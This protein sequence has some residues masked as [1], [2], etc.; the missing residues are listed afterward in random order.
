MKNILLIIF[1]FFTSFIT[2]GQPEFTK[3]VEKKYSELPI[4]LRIEN[5]GI[6]AISSFDVENGNVWI[7]DFDTH[8]IYLIGGNKLQKAGSKIKIDNDFSSNGTLENSLTENYSANPEDC[9]LTLKKSF[10][11]NKEN[12]FVD[13]GGILTNSN[14]DKIIVKVISR[15]ELRIDYNISNFNK[16]FDY[17]NF[18]NLA[19]A[20]LIGIDSKGNSFLLVET[21]LQQTPLKIK[22]EIYTISSGGKILSVLEVPAIDYLYMVKDFQIDAAGNLYQ[23]IS[24]KD[25]IT[26]IKW[27]GLTNYTSAKINYPP[28]YNYELNYNYLTPNKE[29]VRNFRKTTGVETAS[30]VSALRIAESYALYKYNC[31]SNNLAPNDV[32]GPDGDV[33]RT[34]AWLILGE[35][36]KIPY[37]WGGFSTLTQF[38]EGLQIGKYAGDINTA[39]VSNYAVGVDC[40]GFV[41]R[42]W[43]LSYH[44]STSDMP[45]ITKQ[46]SSWDDLKPGDAIHKVGHVRLFVNRTSDGAL[47]VIESSARDWDVSYWTY[48]PSDLTAY[49]PRYY[50]GMVSD[51]SLQQPEL[52]SVLLQNDGNAEITWQCDTSNVI[53]YKLYKSD[54]G[55]TWNILKDITDLSSLNTTVS[56][57]D[58]VEYFRI[59]SVLNN[60]PSYSESDWSNVLGTG[61]FASAKKKVLI[62]D[63]FNRESGDWRANLT[64]FTSTYGEALSKLGINFE[65]VKNSQVINSDVDL[66][67]YDAVYWMLGDESTVDETFSSVEQIKVKN[68]LE[69]GGNLFVSGS[70]IGWDLDH[71]GNSMDKDFYHNYLK[72][73]Y[74]EDNSNSNYVSG[75]D[76]SSLNGSDFYFAQTYEVNYPD[77]IG[78]Y[79]G[80]SLCMKYSNG[81]GAGLE[82][83]GT[84][85]SSNALAKLINLGFPLESTAND[86]EFDSVISKSLTYFFSTVTSV[87]KPAS[88]RKSYDLS[89][90]YPN[91]FNPS[92]TIKFTIPKRSYVSL[93]VYDVLGR[94]I[95]TMV[96]GLR[97]EGQHK[98]IFTG[99][100]LA[101]G[102]YIYKLDVKPVDGLGS[103]SDVKKLLFLK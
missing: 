10:L 86:A 24:D 77:V 44:S 2:F 35:N 97:S 29:S 5:S 11:S 34:P 68:Y 1:T 84:F 20:E 88:N 37:M 101:S 98:V 22:K 38:K 32:K 6:Y 40:S 45:Y 96:N 48:K 7:Q 100:N 52:K 78:S 76:N 50:N 47:R 74:V 16:Y 51:Y 71:K 72:A 67:K 82:Y 19:Y 89:Q 75:V 53:A 57:D 54:D 94:L 92:T 55:I 15:N 65:S 83:S 62:V 4:H 81:K 14:N 43:N 21:Y 25:K 85:G 66:T 58:S 91:P 13:N 56:M 30:R 8:K 28:E 93:K 103:F 31:N 87:A 26:M 23:L 61:N 102:T 63:G 95:S 27:S 73:V 79:G 80:S 12:L 41:S 39:G 69:N 3:L 99:K 70:E 46:Y 64:T 59:S 36:A 90:N 49:T 42:C 60:P 18:S 33:V 17:N 9:N